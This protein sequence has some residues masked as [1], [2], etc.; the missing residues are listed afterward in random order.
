MPSYAF[1][2]PPPL[3]FALAAALILFK[4]NSSC[5]KNHKDL[6]CWKIWILEKKT[7]WSAKRLHSSSRFILEDRNTARLIL[8]KNSLPKMN[9]MRLSKTRAHKLKCVCVQ[10]REK[11]GKISEIHASKCNKNSPKDSYIVTTYYKC[12]TKLLYV[13]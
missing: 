2:S 13:I 12:C 9:L 8:I 11:K 10:G 3:Y 1:Q 7:K 6:K 5:D 4:Y